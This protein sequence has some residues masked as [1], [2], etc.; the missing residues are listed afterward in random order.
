MPTVLDDT[1]PSPCW[2]AGVCVCSEVG[3]KRRSFAS[4]FLVALKSVFKRKTEMFEL[5]RASSIYVLLQGYRRGYAAGDP[6]EEEQFWHIAD[7]DLSPYEITIMDCA[8][9]GEVNARGHRLLEATGQWYHH[10]EAFALCQGMD[11]VWT[12]TFFRLDESNRPVPSFAPNFASVYT[13]GEPEVAFWNTSRKRKASAKRHARAARADADDAVGDGAGDDNEP[14]DDIGEGPV[15]DAQWADEG[16]DPEEIAAVAAEVEDF[17][18]AMLEA[19]I[20]A[21]V[22]RMHN[23]TINV[24]C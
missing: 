23:V 11:L 20:E 17:L 9:D 13:I 22:V 4:K 8:W 3:R 15:A 10:H 18:G 14:I 7:V 2:R 21:L 1:P 16:D 5:L 6:P 24:K 19:D 12:A